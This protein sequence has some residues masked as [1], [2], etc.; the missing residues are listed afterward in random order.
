MQPIQDT[1]DLLEKV[2]VM[3]YNL[4]L[5]REKEKEV[6]RMTARANL[7]IFQESGSIAYNVLYSMCWH[8]QKAFTKRLDKTYSR[9]LSR[10]NP[11][12]FFQQT[13][14]STEYVLYCK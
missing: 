9:Y 3:S 10:I 11:D 14:V 2:N 12:S 6:K 8:F 7:K 5:T 13:G 1:M 4:F